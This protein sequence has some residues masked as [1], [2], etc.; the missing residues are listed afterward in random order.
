MSKYVKPKSKVP[1]HHLAGDDRTGIT[2]YSAGGVK[3]KNLRQNNAGANGTRAGEPGMQMGDRLTHG[4]S[5]IMRLSL[6]VM[7]L[8]AIT[9]G[10]LVLEV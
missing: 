2:D 10:V 4:V 6:F 7:N 8:A 1:R 3:A 5:F 9:M